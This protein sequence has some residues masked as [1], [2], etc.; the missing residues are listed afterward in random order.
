M[1]IWKKMGVGV[2]FSEHSVH[3]I[4]LQKVHTCTVWLDH[5]AVLCCKTHY[6]GPCF[7]LNV[8]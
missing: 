2:F 1:E 7:A 4:L 5:K 6:F 8:L 3:T